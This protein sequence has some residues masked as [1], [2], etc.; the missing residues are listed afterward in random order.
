MLFWSE[1]TFFMLQ[2]V[3]CLF[4][5]PNGEYG[6]FFASNFNL[7]FLFPNGVYTYKWT[8]FC[9]VLLQFANCF[10]FPRMVWLIIFCCNLLFLFPEWCEWTVFK[11]AVLQQFA[12][13]SN[14]ADGIMQ[15]RFPLLLKGFS[16][17]HQDFDVISKCI[18]W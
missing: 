14:S 8:F 3:I 17:F 9:F 6:H 16:R 12:V 18:Q 11:F 1:W 10:F 4:F 15:L 5:P 2:F 13:F 7:F